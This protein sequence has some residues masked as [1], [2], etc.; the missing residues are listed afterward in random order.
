MRQGER[1]E[2]RGSERRA[3]ASMSASATVDYY[4][5][6]AMERLHLDDPVRE[7]L[8]APQ[9]EVHV[10][11]PVKLSGGRLRVFNG[12]RVQH[13]NVR[14]PFKGGLRFHPEVDLDEVR[15]MASLMTWK[16]ALVE[17]PF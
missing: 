5:D 12:Y 17:L 4:L 15:A 9:Q 13:N 6:G 11:L 10:R 3:P 1:L 2:R 16:C 8:R 14:G 7:V